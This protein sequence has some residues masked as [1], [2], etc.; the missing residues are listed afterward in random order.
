M[1]RGGVDTEM[2]LQ[3]KLVAVEAPRNSAATKD[4]I[5]QD[6]QDDSQGGMRFFM[7]AFAR[8]DRHAML[9]SLQL[10]AGTGERAI[11]SVEIRWPA[12][13]VQVIAKPAAD[14]VLRVEEPAK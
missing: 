14:G 5:K 11:A 10:P 13:A 3:A 9:L 1:Q 7:P 2:A 6:R 4:K 8:D 12:G